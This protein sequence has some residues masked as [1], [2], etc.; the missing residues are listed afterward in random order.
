MVIAARRE[1]I[2][3]S[4]RL[5]SSSLERNPSSDSLFLDLLRADA[6][7]GKELA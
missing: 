2:C 5:I 1:R 6:T 3:S 7:R 4:S